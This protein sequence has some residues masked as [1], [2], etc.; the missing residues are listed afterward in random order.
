MPAIIKVGPD[1]HEFEFEEGTPDHVQTAF[2]QRYYGTS[3]QALRDRANASTALAPLTKRGLGERWGDVF[4]HTFNTSWIAEGWRA[5]ADDVADEIDNIGKPDQNPG[6]F[7]ANPARLVSQL[8]FSPMI[9]VDGLGGGSS[10]RSIAD[11]MISDERDRR[12]EFNAVSRDDPFYRANGGWFGKTVHG[13]AALTATL[14]AAAA[15]PTSWLTGGQSIWA[16]MGV[17][18]TLAG[19]AD[20]LGQL[21]GVDTGVQDK[22]RIEQTALSAAAGAAF[23]GVGET[24]AARFSRNVGTNPPNESQIAQ[25]LRSELDLDDAINVPAL[26]TADF[27]TRVTVP[28]RTDVPRL[29]G[30][31]ATA[32]SPKVGPTEPPKTG[33]IVQPAKASDEAGAKA[34]APDGDAAK[35][36]DDPWNG[37]DWG[38]VGSPERAKAALAHLDRLRTLIKPEQIGKFISYLGR[39]TIEVADDAT[40]WNKDFFDFDTLHNDP[41]KFEELAN[42]MADIFRPLYDA[43]GQATQTWKSVQ[44]RQNMFGITLSD[45]IK[46]HSDISSE[47]GV[48]ARL[49][50]LETIAIQHTDELVGTMKQLETELNSGVKD[51]ATI[52]RVAA[53]LQASTL[54]DGMAAGSKSEIGRALNILKA[55]KKR[56]RMVN[57]IQE[58]WDSLAASLNSTNMDDAA[59]R[60]ALKRLREAYGQDGA[61]GLKEEVRKIRSMSWDEYLSYYIVTGYLSNPWT[62]FWNATGAVTHSTM[63]IGERYVAASITSPVRR[64]LGG[65]NTS[66]E[67]VTF[68]EANAYASGI[69]QAFT[70][71]SRMALRAFIDAKPITDAATSIG[72]SARMVPFEFNA[73]RRLKWRKGG[74]K[75][76]PDMAGTAVFGTLRTLGLRPS[77]AMDEFTKVMGRRMELN[78]LAVR[79]ASYRSARLK[80][81]EAKAV[82]SRTLQNVTQKPTAV[83][84]ARAKEAFTETGQEFDRAKIYAGDTRLEEAADVLA[85]VNLQ[86]MANDY[87]RLLAF[88]KTGPTVEAFER[89]L[90]RLKFMKALYV[91]FFRTPIN[92]VRAGMVDRNPALGWITKENRAAFKDYFAAIDGQERALTR[93]GAEADL[94]MARMVSGMAFMGTASLLFCNGDL[95]GK[96]SKAEEQDGIKSYSI[97]IGGRW[98]SY[99]RLSPVAEMLGMVADMHQT[100]RDKEVSDDAL[101]AMA[102]GVL[103][104]INNNIIN[105]AA[106]RGI[107]DFFDLLD[108]SFAQTESSAGQRLGITVFKKMGDS[109]VPAIVRNAAWGQD[110]VMRQANGFLEAFAVNLPG[111]TET[112][113]ERRDWLGE[114]ITR[115]NVLVPIAGTTMTDDVVRREVS[116]LAQNDPDLLLATQPPAR[117]NGQ[118][119]TPREH[120]RLLEI[121]GQ[122]FRSNATGLTMHEALTELLGTQD[123]INMADPQRAREIKKLVSRYRKQANSAIKR[124]DYPELDDMV[125]RTGLAEAIDY[126]EERGFDAY[127]IEGRSRRYGVDADAAQSLLNFQPGQ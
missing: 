31:E 79:E 63:T 123:Y 109:L 10:M 96:R 66:A 84:L 124:G 122:E 51:A 14:T 91:P 46:T 52:E 78:A 108:P 98:F 72:D 12:S 48:A 21:D 97:R 125:D 42:V 100:M 90:N 23:T 26:T 76:I 54:I 56:T 114:E 20:A 50:A 19:G 18:A 112:V 74:I 65:K 111:L 106:L 86:E 89:A 115:T 70:D 38:L 53:Q 5:G 15:D 67:G 92:L 62:A 27:N 87:A 55:Q 101:S 6:E 88:Q 81:K 116:V 35:P 11:D 110:P 80:G 7:I 43:A 29:T 47:G 13:G 39:E 95:V 37:V 16:K 40:H 104:A 59:M 118:K 25:S 4:S 94:V 103:G 69:H 49:H 102:G 41:D 85:A 44:D 22:F 17:Q 30:P 119:I 99:S 83:A 3:A 82:F 58:Q 45:A 126:G 34:D 57:D 107:G 32:D 71:A 60:E 93:G 117:F 73:E 33:E 8:V 28:E 64:L 120:A 105:K 36:A 127:Q 9:L 77:I 1:G 75:A 61:R 68:R 24:V 2:I 113:A 121:H